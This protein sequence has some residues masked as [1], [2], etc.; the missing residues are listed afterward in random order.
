MRTISS[1]ALVAIAI[2]AACAEQEP[3]E[4]ASP[5]APVWEVLRRDPDPKVVTDA[6]LRKQIEQTGHPW[7]VEDKNTRI[8]FV[9]IPP[10][11]YWRGSKLGSDRPSLAKSFDWSNRS[12]H[13]VEIER[14]FY[15][16][17]G[18]VTNAQYRR[19]KP[20]HDS[21][22]T[23]GH[24]LN[25]DTQPAVKVSWNAAKAFCEAHGYRLPTEREW[26]YAARA[27]TTTQ[28]PWGDDPTGGRGFLNALDSVTKTELALPGDEFP[29]DDGHRVTAP[30]ASYKANGLGLF[31][32]IGNAGEW[33]SDPFD[34]VRRDLRGPRVVRGG[35]WS[36]GVG[37]CRFPHRGSGAPLMVADS[38]GLR[39]VAPV[40]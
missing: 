3:R 22:E 23:K 24:S 8:E 39:V 9:L 20:D 19:W 4:P 33:C 18:E 17:Q 11:K 29:F 35:S 38:V 40:R 36:H 30:V 27:G 14:A 26:G 10:G 25:G 16:A 15:M 21:G 37:P 7:H 13:E 2:T 6:G 12:L 31:D 5:L 28:F 1:V 32:M 34:L